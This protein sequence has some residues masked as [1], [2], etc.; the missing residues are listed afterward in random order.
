MIWVT[1][2]N[3]RSRSSGE[4]RQRRLSSVAARFGGVVVMTAQ[5]YLTDMQALNTAASQ[6]VYI[7]LIVQSDFLKH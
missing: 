6:Q 7:L 2:L 4:P 5:S 3:F 1:Y